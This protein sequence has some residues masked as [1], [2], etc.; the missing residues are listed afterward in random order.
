[1]AVPTYPSGYCGRFDL[2][3]VALS[4]DGT[5]AVFRPR[6]ST[7][8]SGFV[9]VSTNDL[10]SGRWTPTTIAGPGGGGGIR[11]WDSPTTFVVP[12]TDDAGHDRY[13]RCS[14]VGKCRDLGIPGVDVVGEVV[15]GGLGG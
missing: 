12:Y 9:A 4:P 11:F 2:A 7:N 3:D 5:W 10:R 8:G 1:M 14:V 13:E 6:T 15:G